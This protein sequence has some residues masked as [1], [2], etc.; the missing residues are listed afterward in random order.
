VKDNT[1]ADPFGLLGQ[2]VAHAALHPSQRL[3]G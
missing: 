2:L 3:P 1:L